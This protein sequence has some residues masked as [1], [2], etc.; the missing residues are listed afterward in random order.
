MSSE[1][2]SGTLRVAEARQEILDQVRPVTGIERVPV[3]SALGR[4]LAEDVVAPFDVPAHDNSAM[5]GYCLRAAD[6]AP[7]GETRL[8]VVGTALAGA[9]FS[10]LIGAGQAVRIMTGAPIPV[11]GDTVVIQ[12][13]VGREGDAV[14]VPRGVRAGQNLRRAG[15]VRGVGRPALRAGRGGGPADLGLIAS[16]G[17]AEVAVYRRPRVAFFSTGDE[18]ASIGRPLAIGEVYDS[19]RY[20]LYGALTRLGMDIIDM[21]VVRDDRASLETALREAA[22]MADVVITTGGVSVGEADYV[23]ELVNQVGQV[24]FWKIAIKPGRPMAFGRIGD[25]WF[26]GLP[27]NPVAVLVSFYQIALDPLL[28]LTGLAPVPE[29]PTVMA[30]ATVAIRKAGKRREFP[31]GVLFRDGTGGSDWQVRLTGSQGSG[32][33]HSVAEANC[34]V[35]LPEEAGDVAVG[36]WVETQPFEGLV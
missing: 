6:L 31:R 35:V 3:R 5:D 2:K 13:D 34:F 12:E 16:L 15:E 17:F 9:G 28:K 27:G 29:R 18:L 10:G 33:L 24:D 7:D 8:T 22:K 25:A 30:R 19:N 36:D 14:L 4:V 23:K 32:I 11:G 26:F 21:G 1:A 20:T